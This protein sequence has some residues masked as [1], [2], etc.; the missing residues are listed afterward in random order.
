M[1]DLEGETVRRGGSGQEGE[2][3]YLPLHLSLVIDNHASVILEIDELSI[4]SSEGF[5][6]ADHHSG[7]DFFPQLWFT[8][9]SR[10]PVSMRQTTGNTEHGL[11]SPPQRNSMHLNSLKHFGG[12]GGEPHYYKKRTKVSERGDIYSRHVQYMR[13]FYCLSLVDQALG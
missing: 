3:C 5:P 12:K 8:L 9:T 10:S 4:F 7:H 13:E 2:G 6:L 1:A 11:T